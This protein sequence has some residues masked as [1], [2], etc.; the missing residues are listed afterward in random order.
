MSRKIVR[1]ATAPMQVYDL[2]GPVQPEMAWQPISFSKET[3]VGSYLMRMQ[4]GAVVFEHTHPGFEEF[5]ILEG[6]LID[7]DGT[8]Y[9]AGDFVSFEPGT[10]H[11]SRTET[12]C[13]LAVFEWRP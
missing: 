13:L 11:G 4:P 12:G 1:V 2:E 7:T 6:E 8:T 10:R 5:V 3:G 9:K